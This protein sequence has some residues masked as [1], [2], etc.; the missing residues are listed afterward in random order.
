MKPDDLKWLKTAE[1]DWVKAELPFLALEDTFVSGDASGH[2]LSVRYYR[3][4]SDGALTGKVLFG[5][6]TQGPPDHAHG[7][8]MAALL[9]EAMGG[10][11]WLAGHP[12]VAAQLNVKFNQMLPLG[13]RCLVDTELLDVTGRKVR[14]HGV[15]RDAAGDRIFCEGEALFIALDEEHIG[16]LSAK[17]D[18]IVER[19]RNN[20][21]NPK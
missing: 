5:P 12:V 3:R 20:H 9:D 19:L 4:E 14:T 16:K 8:S 21:S 17:A 6:G 7:G 15:L 18:V 2:R 10:A 1:P 13:T 11:A